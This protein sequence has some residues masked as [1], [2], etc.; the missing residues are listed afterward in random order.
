MFQLFN[1]FNQNPFSIR[2]ASNAARAAT[3]SFCDIESAIPTEICLNSFPSLVHFVHIFPAHE[4]IFAR[5]KRRTKERR[6]G[7]IRKKREREKER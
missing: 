6:E 2:A 1:F 3:L 5:K 7:R 4:T